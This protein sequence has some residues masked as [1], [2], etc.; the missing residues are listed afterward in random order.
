VWYRPFLTDSMIS[1]TCIDKRHRQLHVSV[2]Y[3]GFF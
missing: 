3:I 2:L 1:A